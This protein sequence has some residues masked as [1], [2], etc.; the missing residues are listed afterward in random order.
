MICVEEN[1]TTF[2]DD[3]ME[4]ILNMSE[5]QPTG[6]VVIDITKINVHFIIS[7]GTVSNQGI[8]MVFMSTF[9]CF[10]VLA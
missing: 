7:G 9:M 4:L 2:L 10:L 6:N 1:N 3:E 8:Y 5:A